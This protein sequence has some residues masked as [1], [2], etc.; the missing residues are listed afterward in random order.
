[1]EYTVIGR[2]TDGAFVLFSVG[3]GVYATVTEDGEVNYSLGWIRMT[4]F[5]TIDTRGS[6]AV[7]AK[8][9]RDAIF[10]LKA[11]FDKNKVDALKAEAI[12]HSDEVQYNED[13]QQRYCDMVDAMPRN[14]DGSIKWG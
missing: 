8:E 11:K 9:L 2:E 3:D 4:K 12:E 13:A 7:P 5:V 6:D 1:M 10:A 14:P